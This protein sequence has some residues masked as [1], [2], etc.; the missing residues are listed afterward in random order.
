MVF[1]TPREKDSLTAFP[2]YC[3]GPSDPPLLVDIF[4]SS[5][6]CEKEGERFPDEVPHQRNVSGNPLLG[7]SFR[8]RG[9]PTGR[10]TEVTSRIITRRKSTK[11][12]KGLSKGVRE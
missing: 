11:G 7:V 8:S 9:H 5:S 1:R 6:V 2:T 10:P 4:Y 3:V 12:R